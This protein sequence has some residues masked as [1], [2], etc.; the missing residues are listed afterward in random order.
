MYFIYFNNRFEYLYEIYKL[1]KYKN[2]KKLKIQHSWL[3]INILEK[4]I[5]LN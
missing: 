2:A 1:L 3:Y 5:I 4:K